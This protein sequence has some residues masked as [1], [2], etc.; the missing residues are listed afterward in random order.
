[1]EGDEPDI[2]SVELREPKL[3]GGLWLK[4]IVDS[5]I[6][7]RSGERAR[8]SGA[9]GNAVR[10]LGTLFS[11]WDLWVSQAGNNEITDGI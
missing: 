5:D 2:K 8:Q 4:D 10:V 3:A 9:S 7:A 1:V 11:C 6:I